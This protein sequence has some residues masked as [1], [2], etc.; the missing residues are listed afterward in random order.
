MGPVDFRD[1]KAKYISPSASITPSTIMFDSLALAHQ[2]PEDWRAQ[3]EVFNELFFVFLVVGT[4]VGV[5]VVSYTLYNA[6]KNRDDGNGREG[7]EAPQL[8]ELP[9]GQQGGKSSKLFL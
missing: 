8:G 7:F 1:A 6:Y 3:A 4:A 2:V 9:V 5:V